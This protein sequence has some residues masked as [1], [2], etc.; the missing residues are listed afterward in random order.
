MVYLRI[1]SLALL[2]IFA[3]LI[4]VIIIRKIPQ[5]SLIDAESLPKPK[6]EKIKERILI[7]RLQRQWAE[8]HKYFRW[9]S[10][11]FKFFADIVRARWEKLKHLE[12]QLKVKETRSVD[13]LL[14]EAQKKLETEPEEAE[15]IYLETVR[16][17]PKNIMAY[18]GLGKVYKL[19][20]DWKAAGEIFQFLRKLY[21]GNTIKYVFELAEIE[22]IQGRYDHALAFMEQIIEQGTSEPRYLDFFIETAILDGNRRQ[23]QKGLKLLKAVNPENAKIVDFEKRI[24]NMPL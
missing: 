11:L 20:K 12:Q 18:E 19:K 5:L 14:D 21:P 8:S 9:L 6:E 15:K 23:A 7:E 2:F 16:L 13:S 22:S 24:N 17:D 4:A 3:C 1:F 10:K